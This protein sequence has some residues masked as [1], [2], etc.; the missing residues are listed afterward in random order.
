MENWVGSETSLNVPEKRKINLFLLL[1]FE[2]Q[3]VHLT[4]NLTTLLWLLL[5]QLIPISKNK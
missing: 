2:S 5:H 4:V 1:G 3:T